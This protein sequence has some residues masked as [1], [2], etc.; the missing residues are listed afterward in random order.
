MRGTLRSPQP[1]HARQPWSVERRRSVDDRPGHRWSPP[2]DPRARPDQASQRPLR[3]LVSGLALR[4]PPES[5]TFLLIDYKA[6]PRS[7]WPDACPTVSAWCRISIRTCRTHCRSLRA[8]VKRRESALEATGSDTIHAHNAAT[9]H[10]PF[11]RLVVVVDE[12]RVPRPGDP[13]RSSTASCVW[14]SGGRWAFTSF[15]HPAPGGE[16]SLPTSRP[17][18]A[19]GLLWRVRDD[20]GV[21]AGD[22]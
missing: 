16:P 11:P 6:G 7:P 21:S 1:V 4:L 8:E 15:R 13:F 9:S 14:P 5:L 18:S 19:P 2:L 17:T 22:R 10:D 3:S 12:F 20:Q